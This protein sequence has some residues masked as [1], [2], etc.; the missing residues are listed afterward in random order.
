MVL[1]DTD[2]AVDAVRSVPPAVQWLYSVSE[3]LAIS[4][5]TAV[6]LYSGCRSSAEQQKL[7][8]VLRMFQLFWPSQTTCDRALR[9]FQALRLQHGIDA[10]D[11]FI[12]ATALQLGLPLHTFNVKH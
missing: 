7:E 4:G 3:T 6:E 2:I 9:D 5:F 8:R 1:I 11:C 12:G 10:F